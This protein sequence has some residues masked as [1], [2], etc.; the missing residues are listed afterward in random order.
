VIVFAYDSSLNGDWVAHYAVRFAANT[1]ARKL[2]L[3]HVT[4]AAADAHLRERLGRIADECKVLG[5]ELETELAPTLGADVTAR[6]LELV[7]K[8]ATLVVGTRARPRNLAFLAGTVSARVMAAGRFPVVAIRVVHPGVLGQPGSV[9]LPIADRPRPAANALPL[10]RLLG[11]DLQQLHVLYVRE[12]SRLRFRV[13][14]TQAAERLLTEGRALVAPIEDELR[15]GLE[16]HRV[17][18]DSTVVVSDDAPKEIVLQ[19]GKHRSR[20]ICLAASKRTLPE[21]MVYGRPIELV[22]R[23]APSD[24]AVY[25]SLD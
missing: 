1:S 5:V 21:R 24:V 4:D 12:L 17:E 13:L 19:A 9:L 2:R 11:Q 15:E 25:R 10:L 7:P 14:G 18:L 20:L 8:G 6:L 3:V 23:D 16:P 22:L